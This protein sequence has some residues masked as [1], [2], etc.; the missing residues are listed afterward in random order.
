[1]KTASKPRDLLL[2][3]PLLNRPIL[4]LEKWNVR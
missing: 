4:K 3:I 2:E 1:M